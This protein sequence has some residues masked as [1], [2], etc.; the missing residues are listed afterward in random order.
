MR[1]LEPTVLGVT[2]S[3]LRLDPAA[4]DPRA[5]L[6]R[7]GLDSLSSV[8]LAL[9]LSEATGVQI[10]AEE[11]LESPSIRSLAER[12]PH[13]PQVSIALPERIARRS[14]EHTAEL[15]SQHHN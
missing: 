7:Y 3:C 10:E 4:I 6:A 9:A 13:Q 8:E 12:L 11:L 1:A 14:E 5:P 15:Q 2:A